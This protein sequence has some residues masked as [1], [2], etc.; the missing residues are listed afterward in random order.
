M[1]VFLCLLC[2]GCAQSPSVQ[3]YVLESLSRAVPADYHTNNAPRSVGIGPVTLPELLQNEKIITRTSGSRVKI[4]EFHQWASSLEDNVLQVLTQNLTHL[5]PGAVF[6]AYPWSIF[7]MVDRQIIIDIIRFDATPG[8]SV[9]LTANWT[10][11]NEASHAV[12]KMGRSK[13]QRRLTDTS[14]PETVR[15]MSNLLTVFSRELSSALLMPE[16]RE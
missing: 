12:L 4:A 16:L 15:A 9:D 13:L 10:I 5:Q 2:A 11:K 14:Y 8:V 3:Y 1:A 6:R 7:G